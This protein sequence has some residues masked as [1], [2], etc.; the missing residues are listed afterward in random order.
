V[1]ATEIEYSF[2]PAWDQVTR[3]AVSALAQEGVE[4]FE[5]SEAG[6]GQ[7]RPEPGIRFHG[8]AAEGFRVFSIA[9]RLGL[10]VLELRRVWPIVDGEPASPTWEII[11][12]PGKA[13]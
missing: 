5:A 4:T 9:R 6:S 3:D 11:L 2:L 13:E 8:D 1:N 10:R 7:A 12:A